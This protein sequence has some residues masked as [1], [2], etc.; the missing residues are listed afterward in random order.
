MI[1]IIKIIKKGI[2]F[3]F[4]FGIKVNKDGSSIVKKKKLTNNKVK[5]KKNGVNLIIMSLVNL[6]K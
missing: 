4:V 3:I 2:L 1:L 6:F 5:I